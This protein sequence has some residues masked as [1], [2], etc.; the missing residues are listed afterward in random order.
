MIT[1]Y[2]PATGTEQSVSGA[3]VS[4]AMLYLN[5][6]IELR[7]ISQLLS[8]GTVTDQLSD[9]RADVMSDSSNPII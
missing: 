1:L 2:N 9:M 5:I 6:L 4:D 7:V 8:Q 3:Q